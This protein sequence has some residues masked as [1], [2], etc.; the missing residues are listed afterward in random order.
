MTLRK[1]IIFIIFFSSSLC[2]AGDI[3]APSIIKDKNVSEYLKILYLNHNN[4]EIITSDPNGNRKGNFGD[5]V[6][7]NNSGTYYV[8]ICVSEP[9]G[10]VWK[11]SLLT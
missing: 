2:Y 8:E 6:I 11:K 1:S 7:Y 9:S 10:T 3:P 4:L 5:I